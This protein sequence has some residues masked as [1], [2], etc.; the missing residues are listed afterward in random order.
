MDF[1]NS[2]INYRRYLKRRNYS[3]HTVKNYLSMLKQFVLWLDVPLELADHHN[4]SAYIDHMLRK[5]LKPKTI[6][7]HIAC[8]SGFYKYIYYEEEKKII[9]PVR[10][11]HSLRMPK[12]LPR[13]VKDEDI[14]VFFNL[15][16]NRRDYA[17]FRLMLRCG[18]RVEEVADLTIDCLDLKHRKI[19]IKHGKGGKGRAVCVSHDA[20]SALNAY[21]KHRRPAKRVKKIFLVEKGTYKSQPISVRG[22]QKRMEYYAKKS[23]LKLSCHS[24][25]HTMATQLLNADAELSSIQDL[26]G[27][28]WITTTQRYS[29][30]SNVKVQRDYFKA[31]SVILSKQKTVFKKPVPTSMVPVIKK[32]LDRR[33]RLNL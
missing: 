29:K 1:T 11:S 31:M 18:L 19:I 20:A 14:D 7:C 2:I 12:P 32:G 26:L 15:I 30:I 28:N 16:K 24:L 27:H 21:L 8:I 25:R 17:M 5:R 9:N 4:I 10:S 33:E 23:G 13:Y 22:I 6:N 3:S